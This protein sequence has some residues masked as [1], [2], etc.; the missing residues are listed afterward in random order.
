M[1]YFIYSRRGNKVKRILLQL[2]ILCFSTS[3][4]FAGS[5]QNIDNAVTYIYFNQS[6]DGS[7]N[8]TTISAADVTAEVLNS[9]SIM[10]RMEFHY[11]NGLNWLNTQN[12]SDIDFQAR[13]TVLLNSA[14]NLNILLSNR[15]QSGGWATYPDYANNTILDTALAIHAL[16]AA[17]Y[18]DYSILYQAINF[19][20]TTQNSDGGW[21]STSGSESNAYVTAQVL[22][23][24]NAYNSVFLLQDSI[25]KAS[26]YLLTKQ[27]IDGGFGSSPSNIYETA[28]S[29]ISLI[30][31]SKAATSVIQNG[32][33]YLTTS[34]L[35]DGSWDDDPYSTALALRALASARANLV[36][37]SI[38]MSN[39]MPQENV[40]TTITATIKNSGYDTAANIIVR[41][42]LGDPAAG[43]TQIGLDQII[44]SL[45]VNSS[46]QVS[47]T[48]SFTGTGGKTI[49]VVADPD[50]LI[51]ET[52]EADNKAS[53]RIWVATAPDLAVFSEDLKPS[54]YVPASGTAFTLAYTVR[55]LGESTTEGFD[56]A[57]YDGNPSSGGSLLQTAHISGLNGTEVRTGTIGV[58][59]TG[60]GSHILYLTADTGTLIPELSETNNTGSVT[61]QVGGVQ[62]YA[63][64]VAGSITLTPDRP[65]ANDLVTITASVRNE[66][67]E[68]ASSFT[69]EIFDGSPD[70]GGTLIY[71]KAIS[72][73]KGTEEII[74]TNW[75]ISSGIH[76]IYLIADRSNQINE[77]NE[78]NNQTSV[79]VMT[80]MVDITVSATDL[81]FI[82][83]HPVNGDTVVLSITV[84]NTGIKD[85]G[86]FNLALYDGDPA[87]GG[88]LLQTFT[89]SNIT[90]DGKTTLPYTFTAIPW[91][92]RFYA[93]A[94]TENAVVEMY[95]DNNQA[96]R[97][98]KIKA[99]GEILGPD[100]A[101]AAPEH[102]S[103]LTSSQTLIISGNVHATF[104]NA[105][106]TK[107][108]MPFSVLIFEDTDKD[109]A[110]TP[111]ADK[112]LYEGK[113]AIGQLDNEQPPVIVIVIHNCD[114]PSYLGE[115]VYLLA[116]DGKIAWGP[117]YLNELDPE[118]PFASY[119]SVPII[120][121]LDG[122]GQAEIKIKGNS[123]E[124]VI[125]MDGYLKQKREID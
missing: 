64:L 42:F 49:F 54:T 40:E 13:R 77:T 116:H 59:L 75:T 55:N 48:A 100:N 30:E 105:G 56:I 61:I 25:N 92:Y 85:T 73:T 122:D 50:G 52:S 4:S 29:I 9:L 78:T 67:I 109:N 22:K 104:K 94:D 51:S 5:P 21:G 79:K 53:T 12:E 113:Y 91:T 44:P 124:F 118:T 72:A 58:T 3:I 89:I 115:R 26:S 93:I 119:E 114:H 46:A 86:P 112:K 43:G 96:I 45:S 97:S 31:S 17:N 37:A 36:V 88:A 47:I 70:S 10:G 107:S 18:T 16:K 57:L 27:N 1:N 62:Q 87:S 65:H 32:I 60:D 111:E 110:Y 98:L 33:N 117:V 14:A 102:T 74:T 20:S 99:P 81:T 125:D 19:L 39:P 71:S 120:T 95:E 15:N 106:D 121:D 41:F 63:D 2:Y 35:S 6:V 76:D 101:A 11:S 83:A 66:G 69:V 123:K 24:L 23:A 7:W 80:D 34:Q 90:G 103:I 84:H 108:A 28:L 82:P 8:S 68:D 38:T